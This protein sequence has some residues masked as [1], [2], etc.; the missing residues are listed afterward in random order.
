MVRSTPASQC[1]HALDHT[2]AAEDPWICPWLI[3]RFVDKDAQFLYVPPKEVL[4]AAKKHD[5]VPYDIPERRLSRTTERLSSFDA[6]F[7]S[8]IASTIRHCS[9]SR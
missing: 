6:F 3:A 4:E 9:G 1:Q 7:S 5:A 8:T 2:R